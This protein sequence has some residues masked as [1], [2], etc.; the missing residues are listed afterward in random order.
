[1]KQ[2]RIILGLLFGMS[3]LAVSCSKLNSADSGPQQVSETN[4]TGTEVV[5]VDTLHQ[6]ADGPPGMVWIPGGTYM[7]GTDTDPQR[8]SDETPAHPV[9]VD[10]FWMD[11]TEVTNAQ[12]AEFVKATGYL[13]T[14]ERPIDWEELKKQVPPG[15]PKPADDLLQPASMVFT[16]TDHPVDLNNFLNWWKFVPGASWRKPQGDTSTIKGKNNH[17]VVQVSWDD[18]VAYCKWA[19]KRLPTEAEWEFAA[20]GGTTDQIYAWGNDKQLAKHTN[21]W[22]GDFPYNNTHEDGYVTTA[23]VKSYEPNGY[24]LYDV[25]GNVWEWVSD[26]YHSEYYAACKLEGTLVNPQGPK[27]WY[28]PNQPFNEVHTKRGGSF[29][30]NEVYCSS[31]RLTARMATSYDTGQDH[32]G[33]RCVMT[34]EQWEERRNEK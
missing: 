18:A 14:A 13:T 12:F 3:I 6:P 24:G 5:T 23:P 33:F 25:A 28:D 17:P 7:M 29:L 9:K 8:R 15:T 1:M 4:T 27:H 11:I 34:Q 20:R 2:N 19:G 26:Y 21:S 16:S 10:G 30:C 31:Y 22:T 32:S